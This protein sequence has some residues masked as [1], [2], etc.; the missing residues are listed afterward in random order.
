M[1]DLFTVLALVLLPTLAPMLLG[2]GGSFGDVVVGVVIA[3]VK[4]AVFAALM[5]VLGVRIVP[6][7][8]EWVEAPDRASCS[9]CRCS[10]WRSGSPSRRMR[11]SASRSRSARSSPAWSLN[12]SPVSHR[13]AEDAL[14]MRDAFAVLFFVSVGMLLD[15]SYLIEQPMAVVAGH[16]PRR[17]REVASRRS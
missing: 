15:P 7:L 14:P 10:R 2:E 9:R 5:L 1:E 12:E 16:A 6:R 11:C 3:I 17:R 13:A 8:L 4:V